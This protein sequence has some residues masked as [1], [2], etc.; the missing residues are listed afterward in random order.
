MSK[1]HQPPHR[2]LKTQELLL[3]DEQVCS[4]CF[5]NFTSTRAGDLHRVGEIGTP[6]RGCAN[7][8]NVGLTAKQNEF[9]T[10]VWSIKK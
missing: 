5:E 10:L 1:A 6:E 7:P 8:K 4:V 9:G 2:N 3:N